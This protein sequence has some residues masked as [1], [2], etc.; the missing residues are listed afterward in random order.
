M[1]RL[2]ALE[3]LAAQAQRGE[4]V[5]AT[6]VALA[7][8]IRT[9]L[10]D[11]DIHIGTA[12]KLIQSEPLLAARCVAMANSVAYSRSGTVITD[13]G[14]AV[15]RLGL[16]T[17]RSLAEALIVRQIAGAPKDAAQKKVVA[18]LWEHTAHVASLSRLIARRITHL[19]AETALFTGL[20]HDVGNFYLLSRASEFP[21]LLE[22]EHAPEEE[23]VE[24][25]LNRAVAATLNLPAQVI[26]A[27]EVVWSGYVATP[28]LS[29]GDTVALA[30]E[31]APVESPFVRLADSRTIAPI[32]M[33]VGAEM[34]TQILQDSADEVDS[35]TRALTF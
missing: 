28:P 13:V 29:L 27:L 7:S 3:V 32:D 16:R 6:S 18:L 31:L 19:D 15:A 5:F 1:K 21:A 34:L 26:E 35:L 2:Q 20:V 24:I 12:S 17:L 9:A 4:L 8:R 14:N 10:D 11:P 23:G 25:A 22:S 30:K 33:E